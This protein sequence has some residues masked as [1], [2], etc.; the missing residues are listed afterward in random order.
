MSA[1][2]GILGTAGLVTFGVLGASGG[3]YAAQR[4]EGAAAC[5]R[6]AVIATPY[7]ATI[8]LRSLL[9]GKSFREEWIQEFRGAETQKILDRFDDDMMRLRRASF[10][11][12]R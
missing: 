4:I 12:A 2:K 6:D 5:V 3:A 8:G 9:S 10:H 1:L 7:A 11:V